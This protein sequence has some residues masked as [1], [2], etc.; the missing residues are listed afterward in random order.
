MSQLKIACPFCGTET[1]HENFHRH[2]AKCLENPDN[3]NVKVCPSCKLKH[4]VDEEEAHN[5]VCIPFLKLKIKTE[6]DKNEALKKQ[7][8]KLKKK[9]KAKYNKNGQSKGYNS[10]P[11]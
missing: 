1:S 4:Q 2:T 9:V 3:E 10:T 11:L 7:I 5:N 6:Q 8:E